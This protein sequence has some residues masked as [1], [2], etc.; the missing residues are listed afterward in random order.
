M[1]YANE[2]TY[3]GVAFKVRKTTPVRISAPYIQKCGGV[4]K[5]TQVSSTTK[6]WRLILTCRLVGI[7]TDMDAWRATLNIA[8][9]DKLPHAF[10]DGRHDGDYVC[11]GINWG[12]DPQEAAGVT[13]QP[14]IM[15]LL[16]KKFSGGY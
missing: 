2:T 14:F 3:A 13:N 11:M 6:A 15:R 12:D 4:V 1:A 7:A 5:V 10:V 8:D 16:E 9:D